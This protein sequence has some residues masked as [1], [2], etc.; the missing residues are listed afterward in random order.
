M[1]IQALMTARSDVHFVRPD[2][3][4]EKALEDLESLGFTT[5]PVLDGNKFLGVITRRKI[6][7]RYFKGSEVEKS[8]FLKNNLVKDHI[9]TEVQIAHSTDLLDEVLYKFLDSRY[10]FLSVLSEDRFLGI[11]TRNNML[12]AYLKNAG[13]TKKAH[14]IAIAVSDFKGAL[15]R[16]TALISN[17]NADILGIITFDPEVADLKF[18]ELT[19][20]T[21]ELKGLID[22]LT[23]NGFSVREARLAG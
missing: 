7:E 5:L 2:D 4:L 23:A 17:Q 15:A 12:N 8:S 16:L 22:A 20:R 14:R 18:V 11:V 9:I 13:V 3:T 21:D 1:I 19:V 10:D 6:F